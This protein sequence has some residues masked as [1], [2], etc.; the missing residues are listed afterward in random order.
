ME[1]RYNI[2]DRE[3]TCWINYDYSRTL[4]NA[5]IFCMRMN[6]AVSPI[7]GPVSCRFQVKHS[8]KNRII[9]GVPLDPTLPIL[10]AGHLQDR[11]RRRKHA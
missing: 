9:Q 1:D 5:T 4:A 8:K 6:L 7:N 10:E 3:A 2:W 11:M